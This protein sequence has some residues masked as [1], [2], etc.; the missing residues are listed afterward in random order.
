MSEYVLL[1]ST[2]RYRSVV[3]NPNL[4]KVAEYEY[5]FF[6]KKRTTFH[7]CEITNHEGARITIQGVKEVFPD[8]SIP[9]KVFPKF[10]SP[11]EIEQEIY[12]LDIDED[13]K[14]VKVS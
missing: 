1:S 11:E 8:N 9:I 2:E 6:G 10:S 5:Y 12:E 7:I 13:S 4:R 14:V 3:D